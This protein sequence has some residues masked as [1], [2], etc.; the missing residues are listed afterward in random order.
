M[1]Q[2]LGSVKGL[3][4]PFTDRP[5]ARTVRMRPAVGRIFLPETERNSCEAWRF[6]L[7]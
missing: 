6:E 4:A 2:T 3:R 1:P 5:R 7:V